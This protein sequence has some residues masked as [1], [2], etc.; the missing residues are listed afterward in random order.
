M[1]NRTVRLLELGGLLAVS[2]LFALLGS[3]CGGGGGNGG[4]GGGG[5]PSG[6]GGSTA[7]GSYTPIPRITAVAPLA[8]HVGDTITITG[9]GFM[10]CANTV[11][12]VLFNGNAADPTTET[13]TDTQIVVKVVSAVNQNITDIRVRVTNASTGTT[14]I[15][16]I[17]F[18]DKFHYQP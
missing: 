16:P 2:A 6:G 4:N 3:G 5:S 10:T 9:T 11:P 14:G 15:S 7:C 18:E 17:T 13:A 1:K 8:G 12:V